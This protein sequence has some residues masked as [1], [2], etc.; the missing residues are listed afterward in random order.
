MRVA[1]RRDI[2]F[3]PGGRKRRQA[4]EAHLF[5]AD[6]DDPARL[7]KRV[8]QAS[9]FDDDDDGETEQPSGDSDDDDDDHGRARG[10]GGKKR[11]KGMPIGGKEGEGDGKR[12]QGEGQ[13]AQGETDGVQ[14]QGGGIGGSIVSG[15]NT[16]DASDRSRR[17]DSVAFAKERREKDRK[18]QGGTPLMKGRG[19]RPSKASGLRRLDGGPPHNHQAA[20]DGAERDKQNNQGPQDGDDDNVAADRGRHDQHPGKDAFQ[21][22]SESLRNRIRGRGLSTPSPPSRSP[23]RPGHSQKRLPG[24]PA[25]P[26]YA[27]PDRPPPSESPPG[28]PGPPDQT[29]GKERPTSSPPRSPA[30]PPPPPLPP[31]DADGGRRGGRAR[32]RDGQRGG[33]GAGGQGTRQ[34]RPAPCPRRADQAII[35][36]TLP[37]LE[38]QNVGGR[39]LRRRR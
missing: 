13:G 20:G 27:L 3:I 38:M 6:K 15:R 1:N 25:C 5:M 24:Q 23:T 10:K 26:D 11:E 19:G 12:A 22:A 9:D 16:D 33:G 29:E 32:G 35:Q 18:R 8:R 28:P 39:P 31:R 2:P 4:R 30:P 14:E 34:Q 7:I 17:K 37:T 21:Q 36:Q